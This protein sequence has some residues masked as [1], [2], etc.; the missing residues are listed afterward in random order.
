MGMRLEYDHPP[1]HFLNMHLQ[2]FK[3]AK[4][5][6]Q[7]FKQNFT[8]LNLAQTIAKNN[9]NRNWKF[10]E[11]I[12]FLKPADLGNPLIVSQ[13][14]MLA[15]DD[16]P[17]SNNQSKKSGS[18]SDSKMKPNFS[19]L[20]HGGLKMENMLA[21][22]QLGTS[23]DHYQFG[24]IYFIPDSKRSN[25]VLHVLEPGPTPVP[26]LGDFRSLKMRPFEMDAKLSG[27][28]IPFKMKPSYGQLTTTHSWTENSG[29]QVDVQ[30]IMRYA[31]KLPD[32]ESNFFLVK[33][34]PT[35]Y[36]CV[37]TRKFILYWQTKIYA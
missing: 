22:C 23:M 7:K 37:C 34:A 28:P 13:H 6:K 15:A 32:K 30:K 2:K 27:F 20:L 19:T 14:L 21:V 33:I 9:I 29:I 25:L 3:Q 36:I 11:I 12:G 4:F 31:R 10:I 35:C 8:V 5:Y 16:A 1:T 17:N 18:D 26:W 24:V